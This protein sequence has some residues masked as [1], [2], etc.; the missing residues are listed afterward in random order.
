MKEETQFNIGRILQDQLLTI[1]FYSILYCGAKYGNMDRCDLWRNEL[2][3]CS[4][5]MMV[6]EMW[7]LRCEQ[8]IDNWW[9]YLEWQCPQ[10][11][12]EG[13]SK[14]PWQ[15]PCQKVPWH[16]LATWSHGMAP[17]FRT[18]EHFRT[19]Y[20]TDFNLFPCHLTLSTFYEFWT[21]RK[22]QVRWPSSR[23]LYCHSHMTYGRS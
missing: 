20:V 15:R 17:L 13:G 4:V 7:L 22:G 11:K 19:R 14:T 3:V 23:D 6:A 18:L 16:V 12:L 8:T 5:E 10:R 2:H 9:I 21:C 1:V